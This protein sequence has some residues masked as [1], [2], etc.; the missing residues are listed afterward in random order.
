MENGKLIA[1]TCAGTAG[2]NSKEEDA[3]SY[4][5]SV[6]RNPMEPTSV[7]MRAAAFAIQFESPK[8]SAVAVMNG[9]D[10]GSRLDRAIVR[11]GTGPKLI[12]HQS[13]EGR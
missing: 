10:F 7:R 8:L 11:S 2:T 12:E 4:L 6:Y 5:Q 9:D 13:Q 1:G 3:L